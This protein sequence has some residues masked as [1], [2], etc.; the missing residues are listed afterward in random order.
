VGTD[1]PA[2]TEGA[3][4]RQGT[5]PY[6]AD[7]DIRDLACFDAPRAR[8]RS[9]ELVPDPSNT[10]LGSF[11][12]RSATRRTPTDPGETGLLALLTDFVTGEIARYG[13][14]AIFVLMLLESACIPIPSEVT[15]LFGGALVTAP[16]LAPEQ[17]LEFWLVVLAGTLGNLVGSWLAYWAGYSGGRPLIDRWGR[18]LLIRPH[19]VDRAHEWF[20]R[21]GQAAVFFGRLLPVIR[22]FIS[23]PAGVVRMNFWR[24]TLYTVLGCLPWVLALTWIGALLGERWDRAEA[25]IR[26]FAWAIAIALALAVAWFVWHRIRQIRREEAA[27]VEGTVDRSTAGVVEGSD[28]D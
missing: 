28:E 15:M 23:L 14:V 20:E 22:T 25:I 3:S 8:A 24:F 5:S 10:L 6:L 27:R 9:L 12:S 21:R 2:S 16:F 11:H 4:A 1:G 17:Q 13:Y 7:R 18:Y 26:P 19:E